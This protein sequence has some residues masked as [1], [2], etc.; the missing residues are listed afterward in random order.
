MISLHFQVQCHTHFGLDALG[1][2]L[3][4]PFRCVANTHGV[5]VTEEA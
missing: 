4:E 3:Q 2:V 5:Y 1:G